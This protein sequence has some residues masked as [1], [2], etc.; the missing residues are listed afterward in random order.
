MINEC[1][2]VVSYLDGILRGFKTFKDKKFINLQF[3]FPKALF[4][5]VLLACGSVLVR[6]RR[7]GK[8][9]RQ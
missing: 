2:D 8:L 9:I 3:S 5:F 1:G 6:H 7:S 4:I